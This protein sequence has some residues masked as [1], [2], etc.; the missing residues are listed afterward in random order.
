ML[1]VAGKRLV[2]EAELDVSSLVSFGSKPVVTVVPLYV[3]RRASEKRVFAEESQLCGWCVV[4]CVFVPDGSNETVNATEQVSS[5]SKPAWAKILHG[6]HLLQSIGWVPDEG[7]E[8]TAQAR[9]SLTVSQV[10]L[11]FGRV[12]GVTD[13]INDA[14][15]SQMSVRLEARVGGS[16]ILLPDD[17]VASTN[18][19]NTVKLNIGN[20][21]HPTVGWASS[22]MITAFVS[23]PNLS[24]MTHF[25]LVAT[26]SGGEEHILAESVVLMPTQDLRLGIPLN[27]RVAFR[28]SSGNRV[29]LVTI[30]FQTTS[31]GATE[32]SRLGN[33]SINSCSYTR[34]DTASCVDANTFIKVSIIDGSITDPSWR[35]NIEPFFEICVTPPIHAAHGE[36]NPVVSSRTRFLNLSSNKEAWDIEQTL[37]Y[38]VES[39]PKSTMDETQSST[40]SVYIVCRDAARFMCAEIGWAKISLPWSLLAR[41][42]VVDQWVTFSPARIQHNMS[43]VGLA[44]SNASNV[45]SFNKSAGRVRVR[46]S[47]VDNSSGG[48]RNDVVLPAVTAKCDPSF[49]QPGIGAVVMWIRG[50]HEPGPGNMQDICQVSLATASAAVVGNVKGFDSSG[51][52]AESNGLPDDD[53]RRIFAEVAITTDEPLE[54]S[55]TRTTDLN[56]QGGVQKNSASLDSEGVFC[57]WA[58]L[59]V[60]SGR[61]SE[62][63]LTMTLE[64]NIVPYVTSFAVLQAI[65][66]FDG[67]VS[68]QPAVPCLQLLL[69]DAHSGD[70]NVAYRS[71][72]S[73]IHTGTNTTFIQARKT[74]KPPVL[75]LDAAFVPFV[76]GNLVIALGSIQLTS[77][78]NS[79]FKNSATVSSGRSH[80]NVESSNAGGTRRAALRY[81]LGS[82]TYGFSSEFTIQAKSVTVPASNPNA[83]GANIV[84]IPVNTLLETLRTDNGCSFE[85]QVYLLDLESTDSSYCVGVGSIQTASLYYLAMRC[86]ASSSMPSSSSSPQLNESVSVGLSPWLQAEVKFMDPIIKQVVAVASLSLQYAFDGVCDP[87][88]AMLNKATGKT[89]QDAESKARTELGLKQTFMLADADKSG[90]VSQSE[91]LDTAVY[92]IFSSTVRGFTYAAAQ[93]HKKLWSR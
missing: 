76:S 71:D 6:R 70:R 48:D 80:G 85:L 34:H 41:G 12:Q 59:P 30:G 74:K 26:S 40:W 55:L 22:D 49:C 84:A 43:T 39:L 38:F 51:A 16:S 88:V 32:L 20:D 7:P 47:R 56:K 81:V 57:H 93:G 73:S 82:R 5:V 61:T 13:A 25:F 50:V 87:V 24:P 46:I 67:S 33:G 79:R 89:L 75:T 53:V 78:A 42:R 68:M 29:L 72:L 4:G 63:S 65:N 58:S 8:T 28:D 60:S 91:V 27:T 35:A 90:N 15:A 52:V 54:R 86:A 2:G 66:P 77:W 62:V 36:V 1:V 69:H 11:A 64:G 17:T 92:M 31:I 3:P 19:S 14:F 10:H 18:R 45:K 21:E 83:G 23:V 9:N 44:N 37:G